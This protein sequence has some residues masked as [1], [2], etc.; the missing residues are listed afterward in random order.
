MRLL[1]V[2]V[3]EFRVLKDVDISFEPDFTPQ[4][5]PLGS[6]NGGGKSTLLQLVFVLLHCSAHEDRHQFIANMLEGFEIPNLTNKTSIAIFDILIDDKIISFDFFCA[7]NSYLAEMAYN[8]QGLSFSVLESNH[9]FSR[10]VH[11]PQV[12]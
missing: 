2:Q 6:L 12:C 5:F 11:Y 9:A 7:N 8:H 4:V 3:P 10:P 1:R